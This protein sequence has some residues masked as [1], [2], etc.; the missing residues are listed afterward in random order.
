MRRRTLLGAVGAGFAGSLAGCT[1]LFET[2]SSREPPV[3]ENRPDAVYI[4]TH[5]EGMNMIGMGEAGD[6]TVGVM[7]SWPHRFWTTNGQQ[8]ERIDVGRND[9]IHLMVSVWDAETGITIPSSGVT[10]ETTDGEDYREEEV[11]YEMLS[12]RMGFHYG[13][14][15]PLPGDGTYTLRVDVGGTN[16]R[17]FGEF[18]G[19]F[20]EPGSV[21]LEFEYSERERNDISYTMLE[22]RQGN[23]GALPVMEMQMEMGSQSSSGMEMGNESGMGM[24]NDSGMNMDNDSEMG[25]GNHSGMNTSNDSGMGGGSGMHDSMSMPVG[26]APAPDSLPGESVGEQTSGDAVFVATAVP[27]GRFGDQPYLLVSPRTPYNGLV[28][29]S[30]GLSATV[31]G[32]EVSLEPALDPEV[33][34]HYGANV[35]GL[36]AGDDLELV[37]ETPPQSARHEGFE[38]AFLDMQS[39]TF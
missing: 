12:Q 5:Q 30:M 8:T 13:D 14:N 17:R 36:S 20:G 29:P 24:S 11:V 3:V 22:D 9:A 10:V 33:G 15:W 18:E 35:E 32:N 6:F 34:Y 28:I 39:M 31:G 37:V 25:M 38:T 7:Y 21:E 19:K 23:P 2:T 1:N 27:G 26:K 16:V 4:P